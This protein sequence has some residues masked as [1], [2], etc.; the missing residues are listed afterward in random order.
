MRI[1]STKLGSLKRSD[2][3]VRRNSGYQNNVKQPIIEP[4]DATSPLRQLA[5]DSMS[6]ARAPWSDRFLLVSRPFH[7]LDYLGDVTEPTANP[8]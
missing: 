4:P 5:I 6:F 1:S 8:F 3:L 7:F 2:D